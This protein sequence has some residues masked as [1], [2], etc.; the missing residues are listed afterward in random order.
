MLPRFFCKHADVD[1]HSLLENS[2]PPIELSKIAIF[3]SVI[4]KFDKKAR[5]DLA[6]KKPSW[7]DGRTNFIS[8][9][10][11]DALAAEEQFP[12]RITGQNLTHCRVS[13]VPHFLRLAEMMARTTV[14]QTET[15]LRA[16]LV[17]MEGW[18]TAQQD[19]SNREASFQLF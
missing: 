11:D 9:V 4:K 10:Q 14:H 19:H 18:Q 1:M 8:E 7:F 15:K 12:S 16:D 6:V 3:S 17:A 2:G 13:A 5:L